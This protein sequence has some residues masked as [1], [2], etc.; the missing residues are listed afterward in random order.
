[1][2]NCFTILKGQGRAESG[3]PDREKRT[4][5]TNGP[6]HTGARETD[7]GRATSGEGKQ[8]E[9]ATTGT[10]G[11]QE[12][13]RRA[14]PRGGNRQGHNNA[15]ATAE[16]QQE[17]GAETQPGREHSEARNSVDEAAQE[18]D[19]PQGRAERSAGREQSPKRPISGTF[20]QL[21]VP[22]K[23]RV[24]LQRTGPP[25]SFC[26]GRGGRKGRSGARRFLV[27]TVGPPWGSACA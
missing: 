16:T 13:N 3:Q 24:C 20:I 15:R 25:R 23:H 11:E 6:S 22:E 9:E 26:L 10:A 18:K 1:M 8:R 19:G 21:R 7:R 2:A 17:D 4:E 5:R 12:D 27:S 14:R